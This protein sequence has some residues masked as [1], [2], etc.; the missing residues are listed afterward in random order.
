MG[1]PIIQACYDNQCVLPAD[2]NSYRHILENDDFLT[3]APQV[4]FLLKEQDRLKETPEFFKTNL[5]EKFSKTTIQNFFIKTQS[6]QLLN[7]FEYLAIDVIPL[8]GVGFAEKVFGHIGARVTS[9]ID[10]LIRP[11]DLD[12]AIE[13]VLSCGFAVEEELIPA[14]FHCSFSKP[15]PGSEIPLKVELHWDI[16]REDTAA[17]DIEEFWQGAVPVDSSAHIK[18]LSNYHT[19]YMICLHGWRHNLQSLK[20]YLDIIQMISVMRDELDYSR[21]LED[22]RRHKTSKRIIRTLSIVYQE[23][24]FLDEWVPFP[25][26]RSKRYWG[27]KDKKVVSKYLDYVDYQFLSFDTF[28]HSFKEFLHWMKYEVL[29]SK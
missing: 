3:V 4:Y 22:A 26:K 16:L 1:L 10:L 19:F 2:D 14:H 20:Y 15:L 29:S 18:E 12:K 9:D 24:P 5:K 8:K 13:C 11:H 7:R 23:F 21:L 27:Y 25:Y 6:Q 17:F 28:K